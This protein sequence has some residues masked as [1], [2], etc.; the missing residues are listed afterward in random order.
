MN[1]IV[2]SPKAALYVSTNGFIQT[3]TNKEREKK[4]ARTDFQ[5][6]IFSYRALPK[7]SDNNQNVIY[8]SFHKKV[9][10]VDLHTVTSN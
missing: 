7:S 2:A 8:K 4:D 6:E 3:L 5:T 9:T 1:T 10:C